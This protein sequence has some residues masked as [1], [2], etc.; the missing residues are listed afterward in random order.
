[1]KAKQPKPNSSSSSSS[2]S[3]PEYNLSEIAILTKVLSEREEKII[4]LQEQLQTATKEMQESTRL[5]EK[6]T[7]DRNAGSLKT[8]ET[9]HLIKDLK[10]QLKTAYNRSQETQSNLTLAET[11]AKERESDVGAILLIFRFIF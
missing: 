11:I 2:I 7:A 9:F 4:E 6:L 1:M 10:K 8:K 3:A 5:I